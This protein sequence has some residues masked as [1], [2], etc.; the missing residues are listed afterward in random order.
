MNL[1]PGEY[2][3]GTWVSIGSP[4]VTE[5]TASLDLDFVVIDTEHTAIG[6]ETL[7][8]MV[9]GID[10]M[11]GETASIVRVP[12][13]G[14]VYLKRVLDIGVDG[15]LVPMIETAEEARSLV[16]AV[17]Y[18]PGGVR[19]LG[20]GRASRYGKNFQNYVEN[21]DE[22]FVTIAQVETKRG[23]ENAEEIASVDGIDGLFIGPTDLSGSLDVFG[24]WESEILDQHIEQAIEVS[25]EAEMPIGTFVTSQND[26]PKRVAQ[27]FDF[28]AIGKDTATLVAGTEEMIAEY[29]RSIRE[30]ESS[31]TKK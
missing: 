29:E 12:W 24:Q 19:G 26:I 23:V 31:S 16:E 3:V 21:V 7:E 8:N 20:S 6:L 11:G 17:Q 2:S 28:F 22:T 25:K 27:G 4:T 15:V 5:V 30:K 14:K 1:E 13:N 10:A 9:R 18:P